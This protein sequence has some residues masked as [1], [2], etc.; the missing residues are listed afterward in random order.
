MEN[1][2]ISVG[3]EADKSLVPMMKKKI[4]T[5]PSAKGSVNFVKRSLS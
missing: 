4:A 2:R 1:E 5:K 3:Y